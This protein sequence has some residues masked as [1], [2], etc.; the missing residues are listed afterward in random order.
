MHVRTGYVSAGRARLFVRDVGEG[1]TIVVLHGGPD[2]DH[3]YLLPE[4]D[5]LGEH[6]RLVYYDQRGRG[7]SAE[8]VRAQDVTVESEMA[9]LDLVRDHVGGGPTAILAHSWGGVLAMEYASRH[10]D[11][12]TRLVLMNTAPASAVD[13][14]QYLEQRRSA[15]PAPETEAMAALARSAAFRAGDPAVDVEYYRL[16]F[17]G[18]VHRPELL[19]RVVPR[20]R[21]GWTPQG[22]LTARAVEERLG[23]QTWFSP[24]YDLLPRLRRVAAPT[25]VI[26]GEGD[27][28][29]VELA[30]HVAD[31]IPGA[32]LSV[33][34][35]CGHFAYLEAPEAVAQR[36]AELFARP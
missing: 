17:R 36:V 13:A 19:D 18:A 24:G 35:E 4:L 6:F 28:V 8:G 23:E 11:R 25:L 26:H 29:P 22:V 10:P 1:P 20:M 32:E 16:H 33:L 15:R 21:T 31:A 27:V 7:R 14:R 5:R 3:Q 34:P 2:F 12:V 9:D 30:R